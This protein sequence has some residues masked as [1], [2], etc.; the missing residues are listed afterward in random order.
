MN[1]SEKI[2]NGLIEASN[3][4]KDITIKYDS[5]SDRMKKVLE[6]ISIKEKDIVKVQQVGTRI[7][8]RLNVNKVLYLY[9]EGGLA[10]LMK[11]DKFIG[12]IATEETSILFE[13]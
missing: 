10:R 12:I 7:A 5:L 11:F 4:S 8:V 9:K 2:L 1:K 3:K 6:R 13:E